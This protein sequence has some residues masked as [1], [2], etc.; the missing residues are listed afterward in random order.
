LLYQHLR[1]ERHRLEIG[2]PKLGEDGSSVVQR[3]TLQTADSRSATSGI[4]YFENVA[5]KTLICHSVAAKTVKVSSSY[6]LHLP[7]EEGFHNQ[8]LLKEIASWS[9][10]RHQHLLPLIGFCYDQEEE[11]ILIVTPYIPG[12]NV[13]QYVRNNDVRLLG[14]LKMVCEND[15]SWNLVSFE[16]C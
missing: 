1:I 9:Q 15:V 6:K 4:P 7:Y 8:D 5:V 11:E 13:A 2:K 12:G 3:G 16:A 14:R 10:L